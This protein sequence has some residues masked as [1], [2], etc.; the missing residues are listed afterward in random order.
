MKFTITIVA[1]FVLHLAESLPFGDDVG[2]MWERSGE[3]EGDMVL[4]PEQKNGLVED[5]YRWPNK[6]V[7]YEI[8]NEYTADEAQFIRDTL[9]QE[10]AR[11]CITVRP[12][13]EADK[14]YVYINSQRSGCTSAVGYLGIGPQ[15]LNI[16]RKGCISYG[17][18]V[19]EFL[20]SIGFWHQQS[21]TER[22]DYVKIN[23]ENIQEGHEHNFDK[24]GTNY[25]TSYG[26]PYDYKSIMH[27]GR[28]AYSK[29]NKD[30]ITPY[31]DIE[32]GSFKVLSDIDI[33]KISKMFKC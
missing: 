10:Y 30:T 11:T 8:S 20:H 29:N 22:D 24:Y 16:A 4:L 3:F 28:K 5:K 32:I 1:V 27:Y 19:H 31:E 23:W 6:E 2:N 21:A 33:E 12:R 25:I 13:T 26:L 7:P 17:T 18:I 14:N 9:T 15:S